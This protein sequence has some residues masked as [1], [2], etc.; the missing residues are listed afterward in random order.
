VIGVQYFADNSLAL[1]GL[2]GIRTIRRTDSK[3]FIATRC[4]QPIESKDFSRKSF[5]RDILAISRFAKSLIPDI[6][7][8]FDMDTPPEIWSDRS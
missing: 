2:A 7:S 3:G 6:L 1:I 4:G 5:R 8:G